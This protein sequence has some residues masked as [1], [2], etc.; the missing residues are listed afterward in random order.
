MFSWE[1][2]RSISGRVVS[3]LQNQREKTKFLLM[4][5]EAVGVWPQELG[6]GPRASCAR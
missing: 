3:S 2:L 6:N 4:P 1:M 5:A